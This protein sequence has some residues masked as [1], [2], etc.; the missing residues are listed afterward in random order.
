MYT[1][2]GITPLQHSS[3][4]PAASIPSRHT[5]QPGRSGIFLS[6]RELIASIMVFRRYNSADTRCRGSSR[7]N[8]RPGSRIFG[9]R[10]HLN[11][12]TS[13]QGEKG[14]AGLALS[15]A[16][17]NRLVT[18]H[19]PNLYR[20]AY[21]MVGDRHEAEDILQETFRSAWKSRR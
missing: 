2:D 16:E 14:V 12:A 15:R 5:P 6:V 10:T 19:G 3:E 1:M 9:C 20:M 17:F 4:R 11:S 13:E 7:N 18:E 21:R 8:L